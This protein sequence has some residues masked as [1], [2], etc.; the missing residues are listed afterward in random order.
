MR[1]PHVRRILLLVGVAA[2]ASLVALACDEPDPGEDAGPSDGGREDASVPD[3]GE[4]DAGTDAGTD[5]GGNDAGP[6]DAGPTGVRVIVASGQIGRTLVSCDDGQTW[7]ADRGLDTEGDALVCGEVQSARCYEDG[8]T[9]RRVIGSGECEAETRCDCDHHPG[10][11]KNVAFGER[12]FVASWGW[13]P[14]GSVRR[15]LDGATWET[16]LEGTSFGGLAY[17]NG[18]FVLGSRRPMVSSDDGAT[19]TEGGMADFRDADG[20]AL[21][22]V[23]RAGFVDVM[24]GRFVLVAASGGRRD[25]LLSSDGGDSWWRPD[26]LPDACGASMQNAGGIVAVGDRIL[27][28]GNPT[29]CVSED[30]GT[31]FAAVDLGEG[32]VSHA[33]TDGTT[34]WFWR[35]GVVWASTDGATWT[36]TPTVPAGLRLGTVALDPATGTFVGTRGGW[37]QWYDAQRFYRSSDGV[38]WTE[39]DEASAPRGHDL[40]WMTTGTVETCP[41]E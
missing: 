19:W 1:A 40:R 21:H 37:N 32:S 27:V 15:S 24:G 35:Q 22:N 30:G 31:T 8:D 14:P 9:C 38:T 17:G 41:V 2:L 6:P 4:I 26:T 29:V 16:V 23:R 34:A 25:V 20:A 36:E 28:V 12:H 3:A 39:L 7:G 5:A 11:S 13:G 18:R 33:V 10:A